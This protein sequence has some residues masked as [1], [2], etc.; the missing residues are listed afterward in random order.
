MRIRI[1]F[2]FNRNRLHIIISMPRWLISTLFSMVIILHS[3]QMWMHLELIIQ[4]QWFT[5]RHRVDNGSRVSISPHNVH[6]IV[7]ICWLAIK[8][9]SPSHN[10]TYDT[11]LES[12]PMT[13]HVVLRIR[14][15]L[16]Y[17]RKQSYIARERKILHIF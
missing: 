5:V 17:A 1:E 9:I 14:N 3:N 11:S 7:G 16:T 10:V 8:D 4:D 2:P 6:R 13:H 12:S 15:I